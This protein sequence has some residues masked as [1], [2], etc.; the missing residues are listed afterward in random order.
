MRNQN[1][2]KQRRSISG[3]QKTLL[4]MLPRSISK[5]YGF[6]KNKLPMLPGSI[7][8][9]L[10]NCTLLLL[11]PMRSSNISPYSRGKNGL[12]CSP[13]PHLLIYNT[14]LKYKYNVYSK[15]VNIATREQ[16]SRL[17]AG[18]VR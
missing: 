4:L 2:K 5:L 3:E 8:N 1:A 11:A 9:F 12:F 15:G 7:C 16:R 6:T 10:Q 14:N 18:G 13:A 17:S